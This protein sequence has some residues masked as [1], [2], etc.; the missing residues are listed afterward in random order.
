MAHAVATHRCGHFGRSMDDLFVSSARLT[1]AERNARGGARSTGKR[2]TK[3]PTTTGSPVG[4]GE[5][6]SVGPAERFG[7]SRGAS[8]NLPGSATEGL[9][10]EPSEAWGRKA[11]RQVPGQTGVD[12]GLACDALRRGATCGCRE[13]LARNAGR[14][15]VVT[16]GGQRRAVMRERLPGSGILRGVRTALREQRDRPDRCWHTRNGVTDNEGHS[17]ETWR[18]P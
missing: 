18:T 17:L 10:V 11:D 16:A 2:M 13:T 15:C 4:S 9:R 6:G 1:A 5:Q 12:H 3:S 8:R 7:V 14:H